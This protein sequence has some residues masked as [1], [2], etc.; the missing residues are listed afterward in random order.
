MIRVHHYGLHFAAGSIGFLMQPGAVQ[1]IYPVDCPFFIKR[2]YGACPHRV[3]V[4]QRSDR[5]LDLLEDPLVAWMAR[6]K[7]LA[8]LQGLHHLALVEQLM[9]LYW[10][11]KSLL[12]PAW[13]HL[14]TW[15]QEIS[16]TNFAPWILYGATSAEMNLLWNAE[17]FPRPILAITKEPLPGH[18]LETH[19]TSL[20]DQ[21]AIR[22]LGAW[23]AYER[24][25]RP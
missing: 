18:R 17:T 14:R 2:V 22:G 20:P 19:L 5:Y 3:D 24:L 10:P 21:P 6:P 13:G 9:E 7:G 11:T 15:R 25:K 16:L 1:S 23:A 4:E 12:S 8:I